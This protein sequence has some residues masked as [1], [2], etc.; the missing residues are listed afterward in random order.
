MADDRSEGDVSSCEDGNQGVD[1][2]LPC[3]CAERYENC[4]TKIIGGMGIV[5]AAFD[6]KLKRRVA[7]K[8]IRSKHLRSE[9]IRE[10]FRR[11][12][13]TLV[14]CEA[15]HMPKVFDQGEDQDGPYLVMQ[16][17]D[18]TTLYDLLRNGHNFSQN[19]V[20]G[21]VL[22][23]CDALHEMHQLG[24][25]HRDVKPSNLMLD[26]NGNCW[27]I[28]FGLVRDELQPAA[29]RQTQAGSV[30]GTIGY[31]APEQ[32]KDS[33][34]A[35]AASDQWSTGAVLYQLLT[36]DAV[37]SRDDDRLPAALRPVVS[38]TLKARPEDRYPNMLEFKDALIQATGQDWPQTASPLRKSS[39]TRIRSRKEVTV[40]I[41]VIGILA[42]AVS[43]TIGGYGAPLV[44]IVNG[45][46]FNNRGG[47]E[48]EN[49]S[50]GTR[51]SG[52]DAAGADGD[53]SGS[54]RPKQPPVEVEPA[55]PAVADL[56]ASTALP[57]LRL[58]RIPAGRF[59]MGGQGVDAVANERRHSVQISRDFWVAETEVTQGQWF[60][61]MQTRPW[62][63]ERFEY[64]EIPEGDTFPATGMTWGDAV[65]FL[66][67]LSQIDGR[68][69][70][71]PTEAEWELAALGDAPDVATVED[72]SQHLGGAWTT[73][74]TEQMQATAQ[75][76]ANTYGL[77]DCCG[78]VREWCSDWYSATYYEESPT[79][80][81]AGPGSPQDGEMKVVRGGCWTEPADYAQPS[82]RYGFGVQSGA[83][84]IGFRVVCSVSE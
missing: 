23:V 79:L 77:Y 31:M 12:A 6:R 15:H 61:V 42:I 40:S 63:S 19:R 39:L 16:W 2:T 25:V 62:R 51:V 75:L 20:I 54:D 28:D 80:D 45:P 57:G 78:N 48:T 72:A 47:V 9:S 69:Y 67:R 43:I 74:N 24:L 10:R 58:R 11:E 49:L 64:L 53:F 30:L 46:F 60:S 33:R 17:I 73:K 82:S 18:G 68:V 52:P 26:Q 21:I 65:E 27:L 34:L 7:I 71:L 70:R 5:Y 38:R 55:P 22:Q 66:D 41:T 56:I 37:S 50:G 14:K 36:G 84:N 83:G 8:R 76:S 4:D 44:A 32:G 59:W 29:P 81:P 1:Q 35:T 3:P 13:E